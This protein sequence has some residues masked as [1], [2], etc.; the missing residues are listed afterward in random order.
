MNKAEQ[1]QAR[2]K[3]KARLDKARDKQK[4]GPLAVYAIRAENYQR[5]RLFIIESGELAE[6]TAQAAPCCG[7]RIVGNG[8]R[9]Y[10][11]T[12]AKSYESQ[13]LDHLADVLDTVFR[14]VKMS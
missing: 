1:Q 4:G 5:F 6:I 8:D 11:V 10:W 2:D 7:W 14:Y 13:M 12:A 3:L 9:G